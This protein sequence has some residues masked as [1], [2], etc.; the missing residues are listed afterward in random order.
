MFIN[1]K[2]LSLTLSSHCRVR[3]EVPQPFLWLHLLP[4]V[5]FCL[6]TWFVMLLSLIYV[7][8]PKISASLRSAIRR[9]PSSHTFSEVVNN[10]AGQRSFAVKRLYAFNVMVVKHHFAIIIR[11][12]YALFVLIA[13]F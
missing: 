13:V 9:P 11:I 8:L 2:V 4:E 5:F 10:L 12:H 1:Q 6:L 7:L 3:L